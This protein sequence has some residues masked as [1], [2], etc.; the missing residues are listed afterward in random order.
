M[1]YMLVINEDSIMNFHILEVA[2]L[3]KR[4]YGGAIFIKND[5][6]YI[7]LELEDENEEM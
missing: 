1:E 2:K 6:G 7:R 3:Y 5:D 4:L